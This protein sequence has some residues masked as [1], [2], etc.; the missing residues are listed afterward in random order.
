MRQTESGTATGTS[1]FTVFRIFDA[2]SA[3]LTD[4]NDIFPTACA[5]QDG[6]GGRR[7]P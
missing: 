7:R 6:G 2:A 4:I 5:A 3:S 1:I